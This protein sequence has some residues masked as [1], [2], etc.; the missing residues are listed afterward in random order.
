MTNTAVDY[1]R[2]L[3]LAFALAGLSITLAACNTTEEVVTQTVPTDYRQRHPIA[4]QEAKR[5]IVIFVGQARGGLS[6]AQRA[7]VMGIARDWTHEGTGAVIVDVPVDT[8][9][10]RA[11][12]AIFE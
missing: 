10:A 12:A 2:G 5:S 6:E 11:A 1:R 8:R 9:N 3:R 4:V 7:D